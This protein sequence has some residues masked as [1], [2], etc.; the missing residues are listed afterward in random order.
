MCSYQLL[1]FLFLPSRFSRFSFRKKS[2][3]RFPST[4][5]AEEKL[6]MR[7]VGI[8][9]Q[10][11][12]VKVAHILLA[13]SITLC[14]SSSS[15]SFFTIWLLVLYRS[16]STVAGQTMALASL[17]LSLFSTSHTPSDRCPSRSNSLPVQATPANTQ[18]WPYLTALAPA[19]LHS[20]R[21]GTLPV[22]RY[23]AKPSE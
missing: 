22:H 18:H 17:H 2:I 14:F 9:R 12:T 4:S 16:S 20:R 7:R 21:I 19:L 10:R 6:V 1:S 23:G 15:S 8:P 5:W 11:S 13:Q 3:E